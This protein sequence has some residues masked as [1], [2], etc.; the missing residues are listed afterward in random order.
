MSLLQMVRLA[1]RLALREMRGGLTGFRIFIA[2]IALGTAAIAAINSVS[3]TIRVT[4]AAKGEELLAG[5]L[6]FE[7]TNRS[8]N[9]EELAFLKGL[10]TLSHSTT[11]R[12]MVRTENG[13]EQSLAELKSVDQAYPLY[14]RFEV[15]EGGT[16][17]SRLAIRDGI[18]GAVAGQALLDRLGIRVGDRV[19]LGSV[20]LVITG[21]IK[22]EPDSI[23]EGFAFAPRLLLSDEALS[24]TGLVQ[25]G[26]LTKQAY[27]IRLDAS[28]ADKPARIAA[29]VETAKKD[30]PDAGW[31]MRKSANAAPSLSDNI[32][33]FTQFLTLVGLTALIVGGVGIGN[34]VRAYLDG[35]R[36]TI[37]TFKCLGAPSGL[38]ILIYFIQILLV[39]LIGIGIGLLLG[40]AAPAIAL[41]Y[42]AAMLPV[43]V[44][45]HLY[46]AALAL[47]AGFGLLTTVTFSI[48]PLGLA[49]GV[50]AVTLFRDAGD[51]QA[52]WPGLPSLA[53]LLVSLGALATLAV[54]TAEDQRIAVNALVAIAAGF[55]GL[56]LVGL[57]VSALAKRAPRFRSPALRLAIGNI[58]RPGAL[59]G[60]VVLSLGLGLALL[61]GLSLID[62]NLRQQ[63]TGD[64]AAKAPNFFFIDIQ[65]RDKQGFEQAVKAGA[66]KG[67]INAVPMLRGRITALNGQDVATAKIAPEGKWVLTGDRGITY[68]ETL[69]A[70]SRLTEGKWWEKDYR[71]KPLVSFSA[72]EARNLGLKVGDSITVNVL[73]RSITAEIANLRKVEW[74][75]M[76]I[77]F[78]MVFSPNTFAGAPHSWLATLTDQT[79]DAKAE[80]AVLKNVA[81]AYP[82][83]TSIRVKDALD[84]VAS[85]TGQLADAIRAA[86][87]IALVTSVLVLAGA[88]AAG[89]RARLHDAVVM[90]TLGATRSMLIRTYVLEYG[91]LGLSTALF[92]TM[93]GGFSAWY[94]LEKIMKLPFTLSTG[95]VLT[96]LATGLVITITIG[97]AG[98]F[99]ILGQ[100]PAQHLREL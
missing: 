72:E 8:A 7:L 32:D 56:R 91:L 88:L 87:A 39:A 16:L 81:K 17:A 27:R 76:S 94:V 6:R 18:D 35:K 3:S 31:A 65:S 90:K 36:G 30:F 1:F 73:G 46:P 9:D 60:P 89:N 70:N 13:E 10:G 53:L 12:S 25:L 61:V 14:G 84:V 2:C 29:I 54:T 4:M 51:R 95:P 41:P 15:M 28:G 11:L 50:S 79:L 68:S 100:K 23:S 26:S 37:A 98:T 82:A 40:A 92:A 96:T 67:T 99:A 57:A 45:F 38:I 42:L 43:D 71:Q 93:A 58:H 21:T 47:A 34:A 33:R 55:I 48:L 80:A 52:V 24:R 75:S 5:D 19:Y 64:L 85:L 62:V 69:P 83:V 59:T 74:D 22:S 97:L 66:P 20:P 49:R 77:N 78:V 44:Q 86:A 63:L